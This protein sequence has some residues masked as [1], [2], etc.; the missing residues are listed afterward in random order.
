MAANYY[1]RN[2][3]ITSITNAQNASV[4]FSTNHGYVVGQILGFRVHPDF[5]MFQIN[6]LQGNVL[7][8]P[9]STSITVD[10]DT[11]SWDAFSVPVSTSQADSA[12][13]PIG[14]G[15]IETSGITSSNIECS[16][17]KRPS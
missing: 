1:P 6:Q 16:F 5:G 15:F 7:S 11:S 3:T 8:V 12:C 4:T 17:D 10:I 13:V 2:R 9:S 14:S